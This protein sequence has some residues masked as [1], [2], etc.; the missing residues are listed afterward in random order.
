MHLWVYLPYANP[1]SQPLPLW[2]SNTPGHSSP[3]GQVPDNQGQSLHP[4]PPE[5]I[6]TSLSSTCLPWVP[7]PFPWE[8]QK[9]LCP[10]PAIPPNKPGASCVTC[11]LFLGSVILT[12]FLMAVIS[13]SVSVNN[14][15]T[16]ILKQPSSFFLHWYFFSLQHNYLNQYLLS[17][18]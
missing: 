7:H 2:S 16:Y 12:S 14:N 15:K 5:I 1:H 3:Q 11:P 4:E 10:L 8:P 6:Q 17:Q 13:R 18:D 9:R